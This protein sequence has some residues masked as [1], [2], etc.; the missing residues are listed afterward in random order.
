MV[1]TTNTSEGD[2]R[3]QF[4]CAVDQDLLFMLCTSG[5]KVKGS[6][7]LHISHLGGL[8]FHMDN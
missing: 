1:K 4:T 3:H 6:Y 2:S 5:K 7:V 8:S